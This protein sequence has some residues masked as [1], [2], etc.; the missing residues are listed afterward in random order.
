MTTLKASGRLARQPLAA[1]LA[2]ALALAAP[3]ARAGTHAV[4]NCNDGG[5]GSLR[6]VVGAAST[7][8]GDT[9][10]MSALDC[11][12]I[13]LST[14]AI[15][16][17]QDNLTIAGPG[18]K[19][20]T[21]QRDP[22][23]G[24]QRIFKHTGFG[25]LTLNYMKVSGGYY[26]G[27]GVNAA[28]GGCITSS[29]HV[30]LDHVKISDC[31]VV[32]KN[33][34]VGGGVLAGD[35][36]LRHATLSGNSATVTAD[37]VYG[38]LG[39][40]A[41]S[42]SS[43]DSTASSILDNSAIGSLNSEGGGVFAAGNVVLTASTISGNRTAGNG[44]A[45]ATTLRIGHLTMYGDTSITNSTI[46]GNS[47]NLVGG[48]YLRSL[49]TNID[50]STIA[51]NTAYYGAKILNG[52]FRYLASGVF[53][54][55]GTVDL[56]SSL[57]ANNSYGAPPLDSDFSFYKTEQADAVGGLDNLVREGHGAAPAGSMHGACPML[58]PL[59]DNGGATATHALLSGS[60]G[61]DAG[62]NAAGLAFDQRLSPFVREN[63]VPDIGAY[64]SQAGMIFSAS[65]EGCVPL[66]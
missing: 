57:L 26:G 63:G 9:V 3:P 55:G 64:E 59:R 23:S 58:G 5:P 27:A 20:L 44:G 30:V 24:K 17:A 6:A 8:S 60:P 19:Q 36:T 7:G 65:F 1:S 25:T 21:I 15:V 29:Y 54:A 45:L 53:S 50:N 66:P 33:E 4:L 41:A 40:G 39:G 14:G 11:S 35:L 48:A 34:A 18:I 56:E 37:A 22:P 46:S 62:N 43:I 2:V 16:V 12:T 49:T 31:Q 28:G 47:A 10:D 52:T 42:F 51:F 13:S 38:A 32:A 61:I